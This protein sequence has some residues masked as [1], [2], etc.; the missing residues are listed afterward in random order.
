MTSTVGVDTFVQTVLHPK[1]SAYVKTISVDGAAS[2]F[3][4]YQY[5]VKEQ[6]TFVQDAAREFLQEDW[7]P[8][9]HGVKGEITGD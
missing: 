2:V 4:K 6:V 1:L 9:N 7:N 3:R 8:D 5:E